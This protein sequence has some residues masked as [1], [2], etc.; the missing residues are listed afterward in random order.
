MPAS[1]QRKTLSVRL[2]EAQLRRFKAGAA[3]RGQSLQTVVAE[4]VEA[5]LARP[6][7]GNNDKDAAFWSLRG[8]LTGTDVWEQRRQDKLDEWEHDRK[9][10]ELGPPPR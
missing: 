8:C 5:W 2:P 7:Q 6:M 9:L 10:A 3:A 4:A 1:K